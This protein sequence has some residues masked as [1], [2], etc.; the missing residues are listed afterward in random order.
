[1]AHGFGIGKQAWLRIIDDRCQS[2]DDCIQVG[3]D[4]S[5]DST[6]GGQAEQR[7]LVLQRPQVD[8]PQYY[9]LGQVE[10]AL[11]EA[12]LLYARFPVGQHLFGATLDLAA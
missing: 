5:L 12:G 11:A 4:T 3:H 9:V 2:C 1:M 6:E 10:R 8:S 7:Q